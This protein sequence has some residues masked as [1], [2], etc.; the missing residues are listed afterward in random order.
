VLA[1]FLGGGPNA[2][3]GNFMLAF[4]SAVAFATIVAVVAGLVLASASAMAHEQ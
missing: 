3:L 1:Q 4:V 2:F